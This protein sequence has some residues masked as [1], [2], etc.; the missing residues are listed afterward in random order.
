MYMG[1]ELPERRLKLTLPSPSISHFNIH[2]LNSSIEAHTFYLWN[3]WSAGE[4]RFT[5]LAYKFIFLYTEICICARRLGKAVP[6]H[7]LLLASRSPSFSRYFCFMNATS[8]LLHH[9]QPR[10]CNS[11]QTLSSHKHVP[12]QPHLSKSSYTSFRTKLFHWDLVLSL[13]KIMQ[14]QQ[15]Q[16][17][18]TQ[19]RFKLKTERS[20]WVTERKVFVS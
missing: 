14:N 8:S 19:M 17:T 9:R 4:L 1:K 10:S 20:L 6:L 5:K 13:W 2:P 16:E 3:P 11:C 7:K 12:E 15:A 18:K